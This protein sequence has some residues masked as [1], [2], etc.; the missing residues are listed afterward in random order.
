MKTAETIQ[1][2]PEKVFPV[3]A[4][5]PAQRS[6][7]KKVHVGRLEAG[8]PGDR[9]PLHGGQVCGQSGGRVSRRRVLTSVARLGR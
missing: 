8:Y 7:G 1:A 3:L 9:L 5:I 2:V 4:T 6:R